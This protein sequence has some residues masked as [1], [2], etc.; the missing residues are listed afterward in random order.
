MMAA[1][2]DDDD[3]DDVIELDMMLCMMYRDL[4]C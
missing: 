1:A 3:D 2:D 4:K